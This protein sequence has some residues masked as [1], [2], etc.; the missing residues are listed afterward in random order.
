MLVHPRLSESLG[1][2]TT[3]AKTGHQVGSCG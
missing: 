2:V 3:T 1:A